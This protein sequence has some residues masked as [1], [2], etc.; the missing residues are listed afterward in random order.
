MKKK[1]WSITINISKITWFTG[2]KKVHGTLNA[3]GKTHPL[4]KVYK[5]WEEIVFILKY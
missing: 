1:S 5:R 4:K 3:I 2:K